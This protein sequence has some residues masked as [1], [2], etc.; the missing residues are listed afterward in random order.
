MNEIIS[1]AVLSGLGFASLA[2]DAI[3]ETAQDL[4]K[5]SRLTEEEGKRVVKDFQRRLVPAERALAKKVNVAVRKAL[6]ELDRQPTAR[7]KSPKVS[8]KSPSQPR[9]KITTRAAGAR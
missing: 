9:R 1:K 8:A 2:R 4:V 7:A 6:K 5:R 3:H